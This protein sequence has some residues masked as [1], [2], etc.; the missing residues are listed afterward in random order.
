MFRNIFD[1]CEQKLNLFFSRKERQRS[2]TIIYSNGT[3]TKKSQVGT[4]GI[5]KD[6]AVLPYQFDLWIRIKNTD[7]DTGT[8]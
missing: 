6:P 1:I 2:N 8:Q 5:P 7:P 4:E 3:V